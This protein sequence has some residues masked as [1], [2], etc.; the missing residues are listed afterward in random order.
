MIEK[1]TSSINTKTVNF[2]NLIIE[3]FVKK[4]IVTKNF[5]KKNDETKNSVKKNDA[6][7]NFVKD[8]NEMNIVNFVIVMFI[9]ELK[10]NVN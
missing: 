9:K 2:K 3:N 1:S 8:E 10:F 4:K 6:T 5:V 7:K